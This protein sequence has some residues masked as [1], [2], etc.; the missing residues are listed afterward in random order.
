MEVHDGTVLIPGDWGKGRDGR[1][2]EIA[3]GE[4]VGFVHD[5]P[6]SSNDVEPVGA[7]RCIGG[8]RDV[9]GDLGGTGR[10]V[11]CSQGR[12]G[13]LVHECYGRLAGLEVRCRLWRYATVVLSCPKT[14]VRD[15][16]VGI[17]RIPTANDPGFLAVP[18][19][20]VVTVRS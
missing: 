17:D 5:P 8:Y 4:C 13:A 6:V 1:S 14:G 20:A 15:V 18:P 3:Y 9:A 19:S 12:A 2:R 7:C 10:I 11:G 16:M